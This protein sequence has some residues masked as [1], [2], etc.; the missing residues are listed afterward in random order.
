MYC[1][2]CFLME[3]YQL[4]NIMKEKQMEKELEN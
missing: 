2:V 4:K 1:L 3:K